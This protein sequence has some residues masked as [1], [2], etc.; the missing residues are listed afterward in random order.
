MTVEIAFAFPLPGGLHARPA[1]RLQEEVARF[2]SVVTFLNRANGTSASARSV[3]ALV[4]TRTALGEPCALHVQGEDEAAAGAALRKFVKKELPGLDDGPPARVATGAPLPRVLARAEARVHRGAP[5]SG[6]IFRG[7]AVVVGSRRAAFDEERTR[8]EA[9]EL[10]RL[11]AAFEKAAAAIRVRLAAAE[12]ET[13]KAVLEAHL[14]IAED[15]GLRARAAAAVVE[16]AAAPT[17]VLAAAGHFAEIFRRS[18]STLLAE[19]ALDLHDV[20]E[21]VAHVLSGD[22]APPPAVELGEDAVVVAAR[23]GPGQLLA[24]PRARV[25]GLVLSEGGTLS[26]T[27]VLAR[28]F[29]VPCVTGVEGVER[30]LA[31]GDDVVARREG[32]LDSLDARHARDAERAGKDDG[33]RERPPFREDEAADTRPRE[34]QELPRTEAGRDDDRVFPQLHGRRRGAVAGQDVG[35][36]LGDVVQ[37]ERPLGE[38]RA[39]A[40]AEDLGEV[41]CRGEDR[42]GRGGPLD[43]GGRGARAQPGVLGDREVGLEDGFLRLV[44]RRREAH[45]DRGRRLLERGLEAGELVR[46][47]PGPLLVERGAARADDDRAPAEDPAARRCPAMDARLGPREDAWERGARRDARRRPVVEPR[48]LLLHELPERGPGRSLVL[49]LHVQGARLAERRPRRHE[50]E[51]AP[52]ARRGAVRAVQ[53]RDDRPEARHLLLEADS[54]P[55]V[56][57]ARERERERDLDRHDA[58]RPGPGSD[59]P[60][61]AGRSFM[62]TPCLDIPE[63]DPSV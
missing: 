63:F 41:A 60:D 34:R 10:A 35:D 37:V 27:V 28:A 43:D 57:A 59:R 52:R 32:P 19:R 61:R 14:S 3:L 5:A 46:L 62:R 30:A 17:A 21:A 33:V 25:R 23:L 8:T 1:V 13:E 9:D 7:R 15:P 20:A 48:K 56:E 2:R 31:T 50:G 42:G 24:L 58:G 36:G 26:H 40:P 22:G 49:P 29:G 11:E 44:L 55:G 12:Y 54:R 16:G 38:E 47:C 6:G 18:G 4:A 45:P 53:E 51:D 39:P